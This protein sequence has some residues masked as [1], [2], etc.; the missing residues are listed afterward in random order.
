MGRNAEGKDRRVGIRGEA[1]RA[2]KL[3][4]VDVVIILSLRYNSK[5]NYKYI[6]KLIGISIINV[7]NICSG[8][9]WRD[10]YKQFFATR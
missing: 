9:L 4:R 3:K 5:W 10:E 8:K 1:N 2:A 6:A 7:C